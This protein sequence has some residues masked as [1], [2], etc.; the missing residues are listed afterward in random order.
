M[1]SVYE[2]VRQAIGDI[3]APQLE[4]IKGELKA[5]RSEI[6]RLDAKIDN[7]DAKVTARIDGLDAK[8]SARIDGLDGKLSTRIDMVGKEVVHLREML[9]VEKRLLVLETR[10]QPHN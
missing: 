8:L 2:S 6:G 3:L 10:L 1:A 9:D 7:V 5:V 4:E